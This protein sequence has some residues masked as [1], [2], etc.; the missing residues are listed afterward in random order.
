MKT[1][2]IIKSPF[3]KWEFDLLECD[4]ILDK[5]QRLNFIKNYENFV[6]E[7]DREVN[8][9]ID[10]INLCLKDLKNT[11]YPNQKTF[12][13]VVTE[14]WANKT[15]FC[16]KHHKHHHPNS[17][18]S[19]ILYLTS[20]PDTGPTRFYYNDI[21]KY[22]QFIPYSSLQKDELFF[23]FYP[24]K[25]TM[26]VFPSNILHSVLPVKEKSTRYTIAFNT[27]FKGKIGGTS[28]TLEL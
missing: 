5:I 16:Q 8:F 20:H 18:F 17:L 4:Q 15:L 9:I 11:L 21:F 13:I 12:E 26:I 10:R 2:D 1:I 23:D 28:F 14:C 25:G 27:F 24:V 7:N 22:H 3:Y 6:T 19:G